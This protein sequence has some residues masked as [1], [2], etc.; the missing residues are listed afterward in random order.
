MDC[1][2][3]SFIVLNIGIV[4]ATE[5][6]DNNS[7][8]STR[9]QFE[10]MPCHA[11]SYVSISWNCLGCLSWLEITSSSLPF[12]MGDTGGLE[13]AKVILFPLI[14]TTFLAFLVF[15]CSPCFVSPRSTN[16][17]MQRAL[18]HTSTRPFSIPC[19]S[20]LNETTMAV[21]ASIFC[22]RIGA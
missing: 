8:I 21:N 16:Y 3:F 12:S 15:K 10:F 22:T 11:C 7:I 4:K 13:R 17:V 6:L 19:F 18:L 1:V 14:H 20:S 5:S 9:V 2:S